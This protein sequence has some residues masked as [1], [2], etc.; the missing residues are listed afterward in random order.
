MAAVCVCD[1]LCSAASALSV[2]CVSLCQTYQYQE[3][4]SRCY[5]QVYFHIASFIDVGQF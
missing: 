4:S 5:I 3:P 1:C 2:V